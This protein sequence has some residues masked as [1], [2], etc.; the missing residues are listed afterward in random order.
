MRISFPAARAWGAPLPYTPL[1]DGVREGCDPLVLS[2]GW[3]GG[4]L[5][6]RRF[7]KRLRWSFW[8]STTRRAVRMRSSFPAARAWGA[9]LPYT[10]SGDGVREGC[11]PLALSRGWFGGNFGFRRFGKRL[12]WR[13]WFSTTQRAVRMR[14]HFR[15][16][17]KRLRWR[18]WFSATQRAVRMRISFPAARAWGAPLPYTPSGDGVREGCA[19]LALSRGWAGGNF[20]FRRC[21]KRLRWR[22]RFSMTQRAVRMRFHFRRCRKRLR[23]RCWLSTARRAVRMRIWFPTAWAWG[24]LLPYTPSGDGVREGCDPLALSRGLFWWEFWFPT[25][26]ATLMMA[27]FPTARAWGALLPYTPSGTGCER[28]ATL[29]R[30]PGA[31][32]AEIEV[33]D[34]ASCF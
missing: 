6:F 10:P 26:R 27:L 22:C 2:R 5:G 8:F 11:D 18:C 4:N 9:L 19:P 7:G 34:D 30:S 33:S 21:R 23:W 15:R 29:S 28:A 24:A 13:F 25:M 14:F 3:F 20:G 17:R 16:C 12:R 32:L 31:V 1:G